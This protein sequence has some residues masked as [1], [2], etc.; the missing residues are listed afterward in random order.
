M[1]IACVMQSLT[2]MQELSKPSVPTNNRFGLD[3]VYERSK[4]KKSR[5]RD[6]E[7]NRENETGHFDREWRS[8]LKV[9]DPYFKLQCG[10][11]EKLFGFESMW[12]GHPGRIDLAE[13]QIKLSSA[14]KKRT[15]SALYRQSPK[16]RRFDK[17]EMGK[18]L[19][20]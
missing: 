13:H 10:F 4:R 5:M 1:V 19:L 20:E 18:M 14:D 7:D 12:D 9:D 15:S 3:M 8:E 2:L 17:N 16:A 6:H 11:I